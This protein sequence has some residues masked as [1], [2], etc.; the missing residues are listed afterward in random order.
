MFSSAMPQ[1]PDGPLSD[2]LETTREANHHAAKS[3]TVESESYVDAAVWR[4]M[5]SVTGPTTTGSRS[6]TT[7]CSAVHS[8]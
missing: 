2:E 8:A 1:R 3:F 5:G 6:A 7:G 4:P